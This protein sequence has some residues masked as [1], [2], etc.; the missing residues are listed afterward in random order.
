MAYG[1]FLPLC[2]VCLAIV[3]VILKETDRCL[4]DARRAAICGVGGRRAVV[5]TGGGSSDE[6]DL[7]EAVDLAS[8]G[9]GAA[10]GGGPTSAPGL[11]FR[12]DTAPDK[13]RFPRATAARQRDTGQAAA[14]SAAVTSVSEHDPPRSSGSLKRPASGAASSAAAGG[15]P[16]SG[17]FPQ[18]GSPSL[19]PLGGGPIPSPQEVQADED[20]RPDGGARPLSK[21]QKKELLKKLKKDLERKSGGGGGTTS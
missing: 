1:F 6:E 10:S 20:S 13:D 3:G 11:D 4:A 14:S 12:I 15:P 19:R 18:E 16:P 5:P 2:T 8:L 21:K 17:G 7:G 9:V